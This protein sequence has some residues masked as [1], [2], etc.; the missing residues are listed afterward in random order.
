MTE[1]TMSMLS[2]D[3]PEGATMDTKMPEHRELDLRLAKAARKQHRASMLIRELKTERNK[4][5]KQFAVVLPEYK[6]LR[7]IEE[8]IVEKRTETKNPYV[9]RFLDFLQYGTKPRRP[10]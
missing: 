2:S 3:I 10:R 7:K 5:L 9:P 8:R 4:V 6:R 1:E